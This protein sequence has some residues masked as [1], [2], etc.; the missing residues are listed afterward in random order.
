MFTCV[1]ILNS[2]IRVDRLK[3]LKQSISNEIND[4]IFEYLPLPLAA[5]PRP[6]LNVVTMINVLS[7][8]PVWAN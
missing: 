2:N 3:K 7:C 1:K 6:L 8:F 5:L 4:G